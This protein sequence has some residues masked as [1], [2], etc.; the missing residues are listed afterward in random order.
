MI[1]SLQC[2]QCGTFDFEES[3]VYFND[4]GVLLGNWPLYYFGASPLHP[5][6]A[7]HY[8]CGSA[9]ANAF[10]REHMRDDPSSTDG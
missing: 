3:S 2:A 7:E 8:F 6:K 10:H 5:D 1:N 9:C 4:Q